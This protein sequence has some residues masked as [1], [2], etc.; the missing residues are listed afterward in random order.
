MINMRN[1]EFMP[2]GKIKLKL[3][4]IMKERDITIY[5]LSK[6]AAV[7]FTTIKNYAENANLN[8]VDLTTL[9]KICYAL[10]ISD[11]NDIIE[12]IE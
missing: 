11:M 3:K 5:A 8:R 12:Y 2:F 10:E 7:E 9:A 6:A 4:D 1:I